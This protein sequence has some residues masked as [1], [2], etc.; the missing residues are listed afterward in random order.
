LEH[1]VFPVVGG[2]IPNSADD[3]TR[4]ASEFAIVHVAP[5]ADGQQIVTALRQVPHPNPELYAPGLEDGIQFDI[6]AIHHFRINVD[7]LR[8]IHFRKQPYARPTHVI[9][10]ISINE[11]EAEVIVYNL[12]GFESTGGCNWY[13]KPERKGVERYAIAGVKYAPVYYHPNIISIVEMSN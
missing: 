4:A 5:Y 13:S 6:A 10:L 2:T 9:T 8:V 12:F 11:D 1:E 7:S 3:F